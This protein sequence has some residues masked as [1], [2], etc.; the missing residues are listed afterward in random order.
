MKTTKGE[1]LE[2]FFGEI[3]KLKKIPL[4]NEK[5]IKRCLRNIEILS[6][7]LNKRFNIHH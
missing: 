2:A 4:E 5:S 6:N 3:E 7:Y 1:L